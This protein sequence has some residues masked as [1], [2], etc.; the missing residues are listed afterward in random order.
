MECYNNAMENDIMGKKGGYHRTEKRMQITIK[1]R[2]TERKKKIKIMRQ[3]E[4]S[5]KKNIL[6]PRL[7]RLYRLQWNAFDS[8]F[9][10]IHSLDT[11]IHLNIE[12]RDI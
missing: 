2:I 4:S 7:H 10:F 6:Q 3:W 9:F 8:V 11:E 1:W 12:E 5:I